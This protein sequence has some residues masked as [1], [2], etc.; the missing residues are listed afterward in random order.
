MQFSMLYLLGCGLLAAIITL[1]RWRARARARRNREQAEQANRLCREYCDLI[2]RLK[3]DPFNVALCQKFLACAPA[4]HRGDGRSEIT[5][6]VAQLI[7]T[8]LL[9]AGVRCSAMFGNLSDP[10]LRHL[11]SAASTG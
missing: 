3:A 11:G 6:E 5:A 8:D 2:L 7:I 9:L 10:R 4:Y 1:L